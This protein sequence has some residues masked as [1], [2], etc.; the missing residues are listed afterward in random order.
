M[1]RFFE[2]QVFVAVAE[3]EGFAAGARKLGISPP[4]ATR[5]L[6]DLESRLGIK[7]LTRTTR[8]VRVTDAGKRYLDDCKRILGEV[9]EADDAAAGINGEPSGQL[10]I[11]APVVFGRLFVAP[12]VL[13]YLNR[14]PKMDVSALY[15]DR[16]VNLI[17]EGL[18]VGV[19]IGQLADSSMHA[20]RVGVVRRLLC[21]SPD[22]LEK[23]GI[24][25]EPKDLHEHTIISALGVNPLAEWKFKGD[26]NVRLKPRLSVTTNESAIDAAVAGFG[27]S[28][29]MSYQIAPQLERG[30]LKIVLSEFE[31]EP[32]PIHILHREGR[33]AS[34]KV[35][36]F[37]DLLVARLRADAALNYR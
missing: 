9:A 21:A 15:V 2:M 4:V 30:E 28:R 25:Q 23:H 22:Y 32:L 19:R 14:F 8:Y 3:A 36:S 16:I 17:E 26:K 5:A 7:L 1:D 29:Q 24:P 6:A 31:L 18:D 12:G 27:I 34:I 11:T 10:A 20:A 35:R 37:V 13:D 33:Y